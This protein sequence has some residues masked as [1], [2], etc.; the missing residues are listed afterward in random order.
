M[1]AFE[2]SHPDIDLV[3]IISGRDS[4]MS[5]AI[6]LAEERKSTLEAVSG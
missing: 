5:E 2:N 1:N 4:T 3:A 6:D